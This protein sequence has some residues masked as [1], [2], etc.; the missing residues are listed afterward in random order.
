MSF[1]LAIKNKKE[2]DIATLISFKDRV[3]QLLKEHNR[4]RSWLADQIGISK[5]SLNY[6]LNHSI[7]PK[8]IPEIANALG[9]NPKWIETGKGKV[10]FTEESP[11]VEI[12]ILNMD[13]SN[14]NQAISNPNICTSNEKV[15]VNNQDFFAIKLNTLS[16]EPTFSSGCILI[17]NKKLRPKNGDFVLFETK[18]GEINF[19]QFFKEGSFII[20]N[21][22]KE[23]FPS[24]KEKNIRVLGTLS[25]SRSHFK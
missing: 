14:I 23:K 25:E 1:S 5:Q 17:F 8:Y 15:F 4:N 13:Q 7:T 19:R 3:I 18:N 11:L 9:V 10:Y 21:A 6:M 16:M 2:K 20:L 22:I 24:Y 12:P